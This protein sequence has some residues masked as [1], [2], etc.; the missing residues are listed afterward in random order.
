MDDGISAATLF[1]GTENGRGA[2]NNHDFQPSR[3]LIE[4][5]PQPSRKKTRESDINGLALD[6][7]PAEPAAKRSRLNNDHETTQADL[8]RIDQNG[9]SHEL[10]EPQSSLTPV[11]YSAGDESH[12]VNG[13]DIDDEPD[14]P[15]NAPPILTLTDGQS[16][17][18]QSDTVNDLT[19]NTS[20]LTLPEKHNIMHTAWN[21]QN[22]VLAT[23][24]DALCRLW[25][26][27]KEAALADQYRDRSYQDLL[28][29][30]DD[31]L[32]TS[33]AWSPDGRLLAVATRSDASELTG[34]VST[35]TDTGKALDDLSVGQEMVIKLRWNDRGTLLLG[36]TSS[37]DGKSS[38]IVWDIDTSRPLPPIQC[39]KI[40]ADARWTGPS[41]IT[42]CGDGAI[43]RWDVSAQQGFTWAHKADP[44]ITGSDWTHISHVPSSDVLMVFDEEAGHFIQLESNGSLSSYQRVH[45]DAITSIAY[46]P[47]FGNMPLNTRTATSSLDGTVNCYTNTTPFRTMKFGQATPPLAVKFSPDGLLAAANQNKVLIWD[48]NEGNVPLASWKGDLGKSA[49]PAL[50]NGHSADR[51]SGIGDD[52]TEDGMSEPGVSLDWDAEGNRIALGVGNQVSIVRYRFVIALFDQF[53]VAIITLRT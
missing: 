20:L 8:M 32:V 45:S 12:V 1:F 47:G 38:L 35:W 34:T 26:I 44:R 30:S 10:H 49:K 23:G 15:A 6:F 27:T 16:V 48:P 29:T 36:V 7:H 51:D 22:S 11:D 46:H 41:T 18:I 37:G 53:Q 9:Y 4:Q 2:F 52:A 25:N 42:V 33:L 31:L 24:G 28:Q 19:P 21:P 43:G 14:E 3:Q 50:T 40:I 39:E 5:H 13:M 17:G